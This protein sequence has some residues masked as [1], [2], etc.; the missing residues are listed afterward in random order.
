MKTRLGQHDSLSSRSD[1]DAAH[2]EDW[3]FLNSWH[4]SA[5]HVPD[6]I[7]ECWYVDSSL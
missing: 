7:D 5:G 6:S 3:I 1:A 2:Q 4:F